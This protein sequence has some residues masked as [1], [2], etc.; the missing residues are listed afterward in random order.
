MPA[1]VV[2]Q[3]RLALIDEPRHYYGR[4]IYTYDSCPRNAPILIEAAYQDQVVQPCAAIERECCRLRNCQIAGRAKSETERGIGPHLIP[5]LLSLLAIHFERFDEV[6]KSSKGNFCAARVPG[7]C[8][9]RSVPPATAG[10]TE[11]GSKLSGDPVGPLCLEPV[12]LR[13][14]DI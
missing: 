5:R 8:W 1:A 9:M 10:G 14:L 12:G 7:R 13:L 11:C 2:L 6:V 4:Q 3:L